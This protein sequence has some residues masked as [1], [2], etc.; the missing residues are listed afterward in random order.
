MKISAALAKVQ[1]PYVETAPF[2]YYV[3]DHPVYADKMTS[4][5]DIVNT[6]KVE[7]ITSVVTLA[8][9]LAKPLKIGDKVVENA[10][11]TLLQQTRHIT[12]VPITAPIAERTA[13]LRARYNLRIPDALHAAAALDARCDAF[14]TNDHTL[15][16]VAELRTL[17]LDELELDLPSDAN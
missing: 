16:R 1:R 17:I 2:I 13:S 9:T 15:R 11:Q 12:L 4:I 8:E 14:L 3:E 5:F 7:V 6:G 10:Y